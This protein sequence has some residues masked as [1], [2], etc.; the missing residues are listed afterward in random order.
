MA[1]PQPLQKGDRILVL[2][3]P[4]LGMIL[5][6]EKTMEIRSKRL[7]AGKY[8]LGYK[9][10]IYGC[11]STGLPVP[12]TTIEQWRTLYPRHLVNSS[13]LPYERTF[14]LPILSVHS[15]EGT[16]KHPKGAIGIVKYR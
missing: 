12:I 15:M 10:K 1:A 3:E 8:Y 16:Y 7:R 9:E 2:K 6:G 14:G 5:S 11:I 4:W 13:T